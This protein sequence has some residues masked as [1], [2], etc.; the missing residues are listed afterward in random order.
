MTHP[1]PPS[2][3]VY[4]DLV[5]KTAAPAHSFFHPVICCIY[6]Y[7]PPFGEIA[8]VL[9]N[10]VVFG[11]FQGPNLLRVAKVAFAGPA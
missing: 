11:P 5:S 1:P 8:V 4:P 7:G 3:W 2:L 9:N 6:I 10:V